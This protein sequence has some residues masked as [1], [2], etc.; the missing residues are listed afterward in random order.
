MIRHGRDRSELS[1]T[2]ADELELEA[3]ELTLD[4]SEGVKDE[5]DTAARFRGKDTR[6]LTACLR[7]CHDICLKARDGYNAM[8]KRH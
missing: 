2:A 6:A 1:K 3:R 7:Q 5:D 4:F 8:V